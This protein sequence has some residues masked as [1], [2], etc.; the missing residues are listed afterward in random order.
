[1]SRNLRIIR[2]GT[3]NFGLALF[4]GSTAGAATLCV[5]TGGTG[6]CYSTISA[7]VAA[8]SPGDTVEVGIGIYKEQVT[9]TKPLSLVAKTVGGPKIDA[10]GLSNGIFI[11][12]MSTA[13]SP[14]VFHVVV[15]GFQVLNANYEG[16]LVANASD[17]TLSDNRVHGNNKGL[18]L[19]NSPATCPGIPDFET[20]EGM[21][22]GEGIHLMATQHSTIIHNESDANSGGILITDET[23]PSYSNLISGNLVHD[24]PYACGIT[25]ASHPAATSVIPKAPVAFGIY[26]NTISNNDS[27]HNGLG[28]PGAGAGVGIFAALPGYAS[29]ANVVIN[30]N[31]HDNGLPGVTMH[32]HAAFPGPPPA[33]LDN[34][35]IVGN[36]IRNNAADTADAATSGPTGIHVYSVV[37]IHGT[38]ISQNTF[39]DEDIDIAFNAPLGNINAHFNNFSAS[40]IGVQSVGGGHVSATSNWWHCAGG[41]DGASGNCATS[42]NPNTTVN[43][44]LILP[45]VPSFGVKQTTAGP[46]Q[47]RLF[48]LQLPNG[49][50]YVT[51]LMSDDSSSVH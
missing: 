42:T 22:C 16:I 24:N 34:N 7:A 20:N 51:I 2:L 10:T 45:F 33:N 37:P 8:A 35:M 43:P 9:I 6:G 38:V 5:N 31:L 15:T 39:D 17:V 29:Y 36:T 26:R 13:P 49:V 18:D 40:A 14:G 32:S 44:W 30:N 25:M 4:L 50:L 23:G 41:P 46:K 3:I 48:F 1:M 27:G 47:V 11:N 28:L 12:G 19:S 21:D